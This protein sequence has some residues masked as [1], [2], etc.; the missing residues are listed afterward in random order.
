MSF[1]FQRTADSVHD[2]LQKDISSL[3]TLAQ[4]ALVYIIQH[5]PGSRTPIR[6]PMLSD[7]T[8][9]ESVSNIFFST[10]M[11]IALFLEKLSLL[12]SSSHVDAD[13]H[14]RPT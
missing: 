11:P 10:N 3:E 6:I 2:N 9:A 4:I 1:R 14:G 5:F 13:V 8:T 7:N 12:L